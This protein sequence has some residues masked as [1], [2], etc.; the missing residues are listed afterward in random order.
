MNKLITKAH[1]LKNAVISWFF[2][3]HN[4]RWVRNVYG[5]EIYMTGKWKRSWWKCN[6]C[7]RRK[8]SEHLNTTSRD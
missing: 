2:C 4:Y 7:G 8:S 3:K 5:D 6:N 1:L